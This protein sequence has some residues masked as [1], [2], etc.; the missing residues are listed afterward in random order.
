MGVWFTYSGCQS[1]VFTLFETLGFQ[2][3]LS[4]FQG[5]SSI[6]VL[7]PSSLCGD[8]VSLWGTGSP[9]LVTNLLDFVVQILL[10][11]LVVFSRDGALSTYF[12][13]LVAASAPPLGVAATFPST[14]D[15]GFLLL[16]RVFP[17]F[18]FCFESMAPLAAWYI[19][20]LPAGFPAYPLGPLFLCPL[21]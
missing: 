11:N 2:F 16:L 21:L 15:S 18:H 20:E 8:S 7:C 19:S 14:R 12:Q 13:L 5:G 4:H 3:G 17:Y 9:T 1:R 10:C 6:L